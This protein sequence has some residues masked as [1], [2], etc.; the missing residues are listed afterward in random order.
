MHSRVTS[1]AGTFSDVSHILSP[2]WHTGN[3][4]FRTR[5]IQEPD[6]VHVCFHVFPKQ[7]FTPLQTQSAKT[8][9]ITLFSKKHENHTLEFMFKNSHM[10][11]KNICSPDCCPAFI[12]G[13]ASLETVNYNIGICLHKTVCRSI[14][15]F[16]ST[17]CLQKLL[18]SCLW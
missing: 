8:K 12:S 4:H 5:S 18:L 17:D 14:P 3:D 2:C 7:E 16:V 9:K 15:L 6:L 13:S 11:I 1:P 10:E